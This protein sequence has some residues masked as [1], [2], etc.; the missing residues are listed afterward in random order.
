MPRGEFDEALEA[1]SGAAQAAYR[2][3]IEHPGLVPYFQASSPLE[4]LALLNIGSRPAR[5][6]GARTLADLRAIPWVF[7]WSQNRHFIT[8][9]Y[10]VGSGLEAFLNI[11]GDR[12]E[13]LLKRM[14]TDSR[15]FG[16]IVDEVEK[17]L[18]YVD[19]AIAKDFAGLVPEESAREAIY[20]TIKEEYDRTVAAVLRVS[21]DTRGGGTLPAIPAPAGAATAGAQPGEPAAGRA[22]AAVPVGAGREGEERHALRA[23]A[24][25][26]LHCQRV[27]GD[28]IE[29]PGTVNG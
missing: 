19:L 26:Q 1:V 6:T 25:D 3:L 16:L 13:K 7:A 11:R 14:F 21:G 24:V 9:W 23:A 8:G 22:A 15:L 20:G 17:T 10:G 18:C 4:E 12:G 28:G 27:W 29:L 2:R 5:R